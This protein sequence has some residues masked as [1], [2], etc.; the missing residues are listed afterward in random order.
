MMDVLINVSGNW[1]LISPQ[2][3]P[4]QLPQPQSYQQ[5]QVPASVANWNFSPGVVPA[6]HPTEQSFQ[7]ETQTVVVQQTNVQPMTNLPQSQQHPQN[8]L[9]PTPTSTVPG[10]GGSS[11]A[12]N[13]PYAADSVSSVGSNGSTGHNQHASSSTHPPQPQQQH[14]QQTGSHPHQQQGQPKPPTPS[15]HKPATPVSVFLHF[16]VEKITKLFL[17]LGKLSIATLDCND[18]SVSNVQWC[19]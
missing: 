15:G 9:P 4:H 3:H 17:T 11:S 10:Q 1:K 19:S 18:S 2:D 14:H 13:T 7:H 5:Q 12:S 8:Y 6:H 16:V